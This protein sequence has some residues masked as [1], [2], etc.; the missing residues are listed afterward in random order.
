MDI[1][2]SL[3]RWL[4]QRSDFLSISPTWQVHHVFHLPSGLKAASGNDLGVHAVATEDS[5]SFPQHGTDVSTRTRLSLFAWPKQAAATSSF[6]S[7]M[8]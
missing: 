2:N 1:L 7:H 5:Y 6:V 3:A 8:T 4:H